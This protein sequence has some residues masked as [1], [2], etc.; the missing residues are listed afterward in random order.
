[1]NWSTY[2]RREKETQKNHKILSL[3]LYLASVFTKTAKTDQVEKT[4]RLEGIL[5]SSLQLCQN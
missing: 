5:E 1:M 4:E 2:H 3:H